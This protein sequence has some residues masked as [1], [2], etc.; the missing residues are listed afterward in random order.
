MAEINQFW[1]LRKRLS[2]LT[3]RKAKPSRDSIEDTAVRPEI[4]GILRRTAR[5]MRRLGLEA[6]F[7]GHALPACCMCGRC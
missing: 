3:S 5:I 1:N 4:A 7:Y 6:S 2:L